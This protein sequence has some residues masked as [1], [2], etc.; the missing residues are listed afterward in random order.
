M[1]DRQTYLYTKPQ[2]G[3]T[4]L[5]RKPHQQQAACRQLTTQLLTAHTA[6]AQ[7]KPH[8][9]KLDA[10]SWEGENSRFVSQSKLWKLWNCKFKHLVGD[11]YG[12]KKKLFG[13][14]ATV[15]S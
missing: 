10:A 2:Q 6:S 3:S 7:F 11:K 1:A 5:H 15:G 4:L 13:S 9:S 8:I 12:K 14:Q